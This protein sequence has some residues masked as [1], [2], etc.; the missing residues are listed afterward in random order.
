[1][2]LG[3]PLL[4]ALLGPQY[5]SLGVVAGISSFLFQLPLMLV[6]FE[7]HAWRQDNLR[8]AQPELQQQGQQQQQQEGKVA[9]PA[10]V[11]LGISPLADAAAG[12]RPAFPGSSR[13][14]GG[15]SSTGGSS[16]SR[17]LLGC[18]QLRMTRKQVS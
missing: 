14:D 13:G 9:E 11:P 8:A 18:L 4:R 17:G 2:I 15:G 5:A 12:S 16:G 6:L 7:V 3:T 1:M 10:D